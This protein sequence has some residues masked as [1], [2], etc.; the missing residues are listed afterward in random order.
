MTKLCLEIRGI[1]KAKQSFKYTKNGKKYRPKEVTEEQ[2][3]IRSQAAAQLKQSYPGFKPFTGPV[4]MQVVFRFPPLRGMSKRIREQISN[5]GLVPK[6]TKPD[7]GNLIKL[8]EDALEGVVYLNDSQVWKSTEMKIYGDT[9]G[10]SI[11][12]EGE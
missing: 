2:N 11:I 8:L 4:A 9:P 5:N 3:S 6:T 7:R 10:I 1:P 12:M